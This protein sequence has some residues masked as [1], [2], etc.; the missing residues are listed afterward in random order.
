M[1][2][3]TDKEYSYNDSVPIE[4]YHIFDGDVEYFYTTAEKNIEISDVGIFLP[5]IISRDSLE[6]SSNTIMTDLKLEMDVQEDFIRLNVVRFGKS[7]VYIRAFRIQ[8][9]TDPIQ[10]KEFFFG[11]ITSISFLKE[12]AEISASFSGL[13]LKSKVLSYP[14]SKSCSHGLYGLLCG[15]DKNL[16]TYYGNITAFGDTELEVQSPVFLTIH[17][18]GYSLALGNILNNNTN[19]NRIIQLHGKGEYPV[20]TNYSIITIIRPFVSGLVGSSIT[21]TV[22][23]NKSYKTCKNWFNNSKRFGGFEDIPV[24]NPYSEAKILRYK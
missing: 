24:E 3:Y 15:V 10:Y 7:P 20:S 4:C 18:M 5:A 13:N 16:F 12:I 17:E 9:E 2:D 23:C 19:E 8:V 22:G 6:T 21:V 14:S 1:S 11:R